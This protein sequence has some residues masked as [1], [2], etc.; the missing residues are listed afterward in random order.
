[1]SDTPNQLPIADE[2]R[3]DPGDTPFARSALQEIG[4]SDRPSA[5]PREEE[6]PGIWDD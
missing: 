3:A 2:P 1:M 6:P 4:K 5:V